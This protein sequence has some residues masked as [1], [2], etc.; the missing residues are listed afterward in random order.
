MLCCSDVS[1]YRP[2]VLDFRRT[3]RGDVE[4]TNAVQIPFR[5]RERMSI[6]LQKQLMPVSSSRGRERDVRRMRVEG[7]ADE[8]K[9]A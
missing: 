1:V 6:E 2:A 3:R 9:Q 8:V 7:V 5:D 4:V